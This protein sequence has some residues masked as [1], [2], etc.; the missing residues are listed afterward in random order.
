MLTWIL[1]GLLGVFTYL[2]IGYWLGRLQWRVWYADRKPRALAWLLFPATMTTEVYEEAWNFEYWCR[3]TIISSYHSE[4]KNYLRIKA[5]CWP[6]SIA[7][8]LI[9]FVV[10]PAFILGV[11]VAVG[12]WMLL[13][14]LWNILTTFGALLIE[15]PGRLVDACTR[16]RE[17]NPDKETPPNEVPQAAQPAS[18]PNKDA[19]R[20]EEFR[21]LTA[22]REKIEDRLT[23]LRLEDTAD[24]PDPYRDVAQE[25]R[26][27]S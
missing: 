20:A 8:N 23:R 21:T 5:L 2:Q 22:E 3:G 14:F 9:T 17:K 25:S 27:K 26:L 1:L 15:G 16:H 11:G 10:V 6:L 4:K 24:H 13:R 7:F 12:S 18:P 19:E